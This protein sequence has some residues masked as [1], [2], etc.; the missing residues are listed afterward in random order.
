M[1]ALARKNNLSRNIMRMLRT[2]KDEY[3]FIPK[4]WILPSEMAEFKQQF[5]KKK[6]NKTFI[7]KPVNLC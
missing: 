2:F 4:T 5:T 6:N 3:N 7:L 1:Y